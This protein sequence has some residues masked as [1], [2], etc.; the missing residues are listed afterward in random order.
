MT[1]RRTFLLV[2]AALLAPLA[3]A[4]AQEPTVVIVVRH[5]ERAGAP[6]G[7]PGLTELGQAR[8]QDLARVLADA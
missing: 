8:A 3:R 4:V 6:S 5:A 7:D 2:A 1:T